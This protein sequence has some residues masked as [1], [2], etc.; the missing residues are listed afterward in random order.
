MIGINTNILVRYLTYDDPEQARKAAEVLETT[1]TK[2]NPGFVPL[3]VICE[4]VWV[5]K[6]AYKYPKDK[7]IEILWKLLGTLEIIV[8]D[9][10]IVREALWHFETGKAGF[11]DYLIGCICEEYGCKHVITFDKKLNHSSLFRLL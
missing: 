9:S 10:A 5:L 1:C 2:E 4:L 7:I 6:G 11:A 3:V 8:Q